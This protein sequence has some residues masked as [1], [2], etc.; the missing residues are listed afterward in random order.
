LGLGLWVS[1]QLAALMVG[2]LRYRR[3][4]DSTTIFA[5]RLPQPT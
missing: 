5:L 4:D 2:D 3:Q 1:H